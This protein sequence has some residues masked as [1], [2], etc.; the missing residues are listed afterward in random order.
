[1]T[2]TKKRAQPFGNHKRAKVPMDS[3]AGK[4]KLDRWKALDKRPRKWG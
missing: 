2:I 3:S 1:M 4:A